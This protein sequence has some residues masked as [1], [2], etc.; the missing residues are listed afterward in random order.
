[1]RTKTKL[2]YG[3]KQQCLW[4]IRDYERMNR[5][6][7]RMRKDIIDAGGNN[8]TT[9]IE[10]LPN[11]KS[12]ECRAFLPHS[13]GNSRPIENKQAQLEALENTL[14]AKQVRAVKRALG[15]VGIGLPETL[16]DALRDGIMINCQNGRKY[17]F[18]RLY[19]TGISRSDFY[20]HRNQFFFEIA[21]ELQLF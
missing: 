6:Y 12:E 5:E 2:P 8:A 11:G 20:R 21:E 16:A 1:M 7:M 9:Y 13:H 4:I 15:R 10:S 19:M 14:T 17:P 18:E 3:I